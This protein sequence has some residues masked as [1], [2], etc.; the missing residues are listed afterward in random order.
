LKNIDHHEVYS[1]IEKH[2][3][4]IGAFAFPTKIKWKQ[5]WMV[6]QRDGWATELKSTS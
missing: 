4:W 6:N 1:Q 5:I 3:S 2:M